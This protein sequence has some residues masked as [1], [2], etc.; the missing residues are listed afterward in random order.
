MSA[1]TL[2]NV[3]NFVYYCSRP[4]FDLKLARV[5]VSRE[6]KHYIYSAE[7]GIFHFILFIKKNPNLGFNAL[8]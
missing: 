1:I 6:T 4:I 2:S 7:F 5:K 8:F 3:Q